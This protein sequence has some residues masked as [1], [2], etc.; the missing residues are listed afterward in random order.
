VCVCVYI[1]IYIYN[2]PSAITSKHV[3]EPH[4]VETCSSVEDFE[5]VSV[6]K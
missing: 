5:T 3:L 6:Q 4:W 2:D 1:Y